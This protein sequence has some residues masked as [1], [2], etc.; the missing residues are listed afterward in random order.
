MDV[1]IYDCRGDMMPLAPEVVD[2][3]WVFVL[4][5]RCNRPGAAGGTNNEKEAEGMFL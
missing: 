1:L 3:G 4:V 2:L 5:L